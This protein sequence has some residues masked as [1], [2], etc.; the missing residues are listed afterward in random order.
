MSTEQH[1]EKINRWEFLTFEQLRGADYA[2]RVLRTSVVIR[3]E[4]L[5]LL[6]EQISEVKKEREIRQKYLDSDEQ[7]IPRTIMKPGEE[8][9]TSHHCWGR[10]QQKSSACNLCRAKFACKIEVER[11]LKC[12]HH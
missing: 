12:Q 9:D 11:R 5:K 6:D 2:L 10:W 4:A 3:G 1:P 8:F 7:H